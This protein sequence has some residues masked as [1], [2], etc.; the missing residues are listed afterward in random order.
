MHLPCGS[1]AP[2]HLGRHG[3]RLNHTC[4][5]WSR[6][7][8]GR[9]FV[10]PAPG[11]GEARAGQGRE[12]SACGCPPAP[13]ALGAWTHGLRLGVRCSLCCGSVMLALLAIGMTDFA[14]V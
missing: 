4:L 7:P 12:A 11:A 3:S 5:G 10:A 1:G 8:C 13:N 6:R 14:H 2:L 9:G